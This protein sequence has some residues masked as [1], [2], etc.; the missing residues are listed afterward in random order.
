MYHNGEWGT[1][2]DNGWN[3][4]NSEVVCSELGFGPAITATY[5]AF[6]GQGDGQVWLDNVKCIGTERAIRMCSH[7]GW[8]AKNCSHSKDAGVQCSVP[9]NNCVFKKLHII[10]VCV[11]TYC[12][13]YIVLKNN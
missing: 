12:L 1:V 10:N 2:C 11:P 5:N 8:E 9:G 7:T 13:Y 6:Y 3:L 4:N